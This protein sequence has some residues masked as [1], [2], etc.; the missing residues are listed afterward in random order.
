MC[1]HV[2]RSGG[3][4]AVL[5]NTPL[6]YYPDIL[7]ETGLI[8]YLLAKLGQPLTGTGHM[9]PSTPA[10]QVRTVQ[11]STVQYSTVQYS[12]VQYSTVQYSTWPV[13]WL[14]WP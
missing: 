14:W 7:Q 12:T 9:S 6:I 4:I 2:S 10:L 13:P 11:N 1:E 5:P 8:V 3:L